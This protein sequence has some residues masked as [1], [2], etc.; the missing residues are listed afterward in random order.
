MGTTIHNNYLQRLESS[1][2]T[3]PSLDILTKLADFYGI[4]ID[5]LVGHT[6]EKSPKCDW[7]LPGKRGGK[8]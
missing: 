1:H 5:E 4:T 2:A 3:N 6:I 8:K 7:W